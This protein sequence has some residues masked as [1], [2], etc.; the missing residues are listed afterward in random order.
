MGRITSKEQELT[1]ILVEELIK[2]FSIHCWF[3]RFHK[4]PER[5][6]V[7]IVRRD[8]KPPFIL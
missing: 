2:L 1:S 7:E 5:F 4:I 8:I 3:G 6:L